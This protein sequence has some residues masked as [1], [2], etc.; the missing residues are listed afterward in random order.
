M[1]RQLQESFFRAA[2]GEDDI[3]H[4]VDLPDFGELDVA[5]ARAL[6][7][8]DSELLLSYLTVPYLRIPLLLEFFGSGD[9]VWALQSDQLPKLLD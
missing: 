2:K 3:L 1:A 7:Q 8:H 9:R 6:G 5:S 4:I